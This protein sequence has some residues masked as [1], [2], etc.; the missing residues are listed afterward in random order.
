MGEEDGPFEAEAEGAEGGKEKGSW[1][2]SNVGNAH[3]LLEM[4]RGTEARFPSVETEV[5]EEFEEFE[6]FEE[7]E[8]EREDER[9]E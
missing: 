2:A 6:E 3:S 4:R 7:E 9:G 1:A 5:W 8:E